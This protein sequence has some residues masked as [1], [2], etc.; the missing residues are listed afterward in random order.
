MFLIWVLVS[1]FISKS[2]RAAEGGL[3]PEGPH[4]FPTSCTQKWGSLQNPSPR[5]LC[6]PSFTKGKEEIA[7]IWRQGRLDSELKDSWGKTKL[8][9]LP[10]HFEKWKAA[11]PRERL[12]PLKSGAYVPYLRDKYFGGTAPQWTISIKPMSH[13]PACLARQGFPKRSLLLGHLFI[14]NLRDGMTQTKTELST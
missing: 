1:Q 7:A 13:E 11:W 8:Q 6:L 4:Q 3:F 12:S 14:M 5:Q 9:R 2:R 10:W